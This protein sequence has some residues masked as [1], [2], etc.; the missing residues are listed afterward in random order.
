MCHCVYVYVYVYVTFTC[1]QSPNRSPCVCPAT[2][3]NA[4]LATLSNPPPSG[5]RRS[6]RAKGPREPLGESNFRR[7]PWGGLQ[8]PLGSSSGS[9]LGGLGE[10]FGATRAHL[11]MIRSSPPGTPRGF[12]AVPRFQIA[13]PIDV[14]L[15]TSLL[16]LNLEECGLGLPQLA[17]LRLR[18]QTPKL[19]ELKLERNRFPQ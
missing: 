17:A 2:D 3:R 7:S 19:K 18:E 14:P 9:S 12:S 6:P 15:P 5:G 1:V 4:E 13:E 8:E 10:S 11:H 16:T